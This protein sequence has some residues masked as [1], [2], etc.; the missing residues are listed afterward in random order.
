MDVLVLKGLLRINDIIAVIE[1]QNPLAL[2]VI[3]VSQPDPLQ[4]L[5]RLRRWKAG[6]NLPVAVVG[7]AEEPTPSSILSVGQRLFKMASERPGP[8]ADMPRRLYIDQRAREVTLN[9]HHLF[10]SPIEFRLLVFFLRYPGVVF[11]REELLRRIHGHEGVAPR[12]VDVLVRRIRKKID[13]PRQET[14]HVRTV[15][16]LGYVFNHTRDIFVDRWTGQ[17]FVEWPP[18]A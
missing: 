5:G 14:S 15:R 17:P 11:S 3:G 2:V 6:Q 13:E 8:V 10:C 16:G 7:A 1:K 9:G 4:W 12:L 18:C